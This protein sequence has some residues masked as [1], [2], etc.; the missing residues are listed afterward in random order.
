M[1]EIKRMSAELDN[2]PN[3]EFS[4]WHTMTQ[5]MSLRAAAGIIRLKE[6]QRQQKR[7]Q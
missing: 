5:V 1:D 2:N 6:W 3:Y 7:K 4:D